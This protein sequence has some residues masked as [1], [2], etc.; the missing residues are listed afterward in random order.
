MQAGELAGGPGKDQP[1]AQGYCTR[2][3]GRRTQ[4]TVDVAIVN[5]SGSCSR[6]WTVVVLSSNVD[7]V[8]NSR[9]TSCASALVKHEVGKTP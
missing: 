2:R 6:S 8:G 1:R 7:R 5:R 9:I 3:S 4:K